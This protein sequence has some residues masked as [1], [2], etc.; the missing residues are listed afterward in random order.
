MA[1]RS[2]PEFHAGQFTADSPYGEHYDWDIYRLKLGG[3][4][5]GRPLLIGRLKPFVQN[6]LNWPTDEIFATFS[7]AQKLVFKHQSP[8]LEVIARVVRDGVPYVNIKRGPQ[9]SITFVLPDGGADKCFV[10]PCKLD[11]RKR[12]VF[13]MT[14]LH[15][16]LRQSH[17]ETMR[18]LDQ[19]P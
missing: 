5:N 10:L 2:D 1:W 3:V 15:I 12:A 16:K 4:P 11:R 18:R 7:F 17:F 8:N 6:A 9:R 13:A 14:L 19:D